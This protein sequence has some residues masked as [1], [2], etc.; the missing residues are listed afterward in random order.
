VSAFTP[1]RNSAPPPPGTP[2]ARA[3]SPGVQRPGLLRRITPVNFHQRQTGARQKVRCAF[4]TGSSTSGQAWTRAK[5]RTASTKA[6]KTRLT[7][8]DIWMRMQGYGAR[9]LRTAATSTRGAHGTSARDGAEQTPLFSMSVAH[10]VPVGVGGSNSA[11][12]CQL[13]K[14]DV[15]GS[16]PVSRSIFSIS[17]EGLSSSEVQ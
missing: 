3:R 5:I 7:S 2:S 16:I 13:P 6:L 15:A 9:M 1:S 14:L 8:A 17:Y 12:E 11:V 4:Y 10:L